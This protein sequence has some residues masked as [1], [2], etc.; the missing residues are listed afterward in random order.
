MS[1]AY[2]AKI[3]RSTTIKESTHFVCIDKR[4]K[5]ESGQTWIILENGSKT[6]LPNIVTKV[7]S[8]LLLHEKCHVLVGAQILD[9]LI[10]LCK[11]EIAHATN[12][13]ML[14]VAFS[15]EDNLANV[16][17][18]LNSPPKKTEHFLNSVYNCPL[19]SQST[20]APTSTT[21]TRK[22]DDE[23]REQLEQFQKQR[24]QETE[25]IMKNRRP[26]I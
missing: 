22:T 8:L 15:F 4:V 19:E 23:M 9:Y 13:N 7:P 3:S 6:I 17:S 21:T 20:E 1:C 26:I 10:P 16:G 2:L 25:A 18:L 12:N 5:D 24:N 14:P 11:Q